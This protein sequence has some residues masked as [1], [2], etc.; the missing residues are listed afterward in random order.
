MLYKS[1]KTDRH[2]ICLISF[3]VLTSKLVK[4]SV[5]VSRQRNYTASLQ[6]AMEGKLQQVTECVLKTYT[7]YNAS[8]V[9][10]FRV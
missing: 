9:Y 10:S 1:G 7:I 4:P 2:A 3:V 6:R 5:L 8:K